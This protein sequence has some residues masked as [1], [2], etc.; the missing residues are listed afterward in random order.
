MKIM[1]QSPL[2]MPSDP[3]VLKRTNALLEKVLKLV[4]RADT[5]VVKK[6][7]EHG[8][9]QLEHHGYAGLRYLNNTEILKSMIQAEKEGYDA[10]VSSCFFDPC[11]EAARQLLRI[12]VVGSAE[13]SMHIACMMGL[14]FAIITRNPNYVPHM[15]KLIDQYRMADN[16][17]DPKP[18]RSLTLSNL[19]IMNCFQ[20]NWAPIVENFQGVAKDCIEDGAEVIIVGCGFISPILSTSGIRYVEDVPILDP[21]LVGI[22]VA[23]MMVDLQKAGI[24][25]ISRKGYYLAPSSEGL[26]TVLKAISK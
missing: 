8:I 14:K 10:I 24:P 20:G 3:E 22:K 19:E 12:P 25:T 11:I 17:I 15:I 1:L 2:T 13:S 7:I 23:E 5:E 18:I 21:I 26:A 9:S 6:Y 16:V 4:I